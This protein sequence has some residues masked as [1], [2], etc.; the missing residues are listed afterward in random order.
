M[1]LHEYLAFEERSPV[2][3][4]YVAGEVYAMTG[5]TTRHNLMTQNISRRLHTAARA[6]GCRVF[7]DVVKLRTADRVYYPD[8]IVACGQAAEVESIV[9]APL[10]LVEVTSPTT[11]AIDRR[12]KL[13]SYRRIA[14]LRVYLIVDQR[15]RHVFVY[16]RDADGEWTRDE[17]HGE[18][19]IP[20]PVLE[21]TLT[22]DDVYDDIALPP[23]AVKEEDEW[24]DYVAENAADR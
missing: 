1:S 4:E 23:L 9:A 10:L 5:V 19:A 21:I 6:H 8:V 17:I 7:S 16:A 22:M 15:R 13:D 18:G 2:R 20:I 11:R 24:V 12:E 14:S 3:H